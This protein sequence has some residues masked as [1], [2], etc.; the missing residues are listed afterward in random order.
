MTAAPT[1]SVI[2]PAFNAAAFVGEAIESALA[3]THRPAHPTSHE[4]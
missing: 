3:Q 1:V 4:R 2:I